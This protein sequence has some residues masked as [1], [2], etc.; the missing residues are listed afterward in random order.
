VLEVSLLV[1]KPLGVNEV[2]DAWGYARHLGATN[3]MGV[4]F[5]RPLSFS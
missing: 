4:S 3:H 2:V 1:T 5:D